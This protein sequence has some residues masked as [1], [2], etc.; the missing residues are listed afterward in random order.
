MNQHVYQIRVKMVDT[1]LHWVILTHAVAHQTSQETF[2]RLV[3][4]KA[5]KG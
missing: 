2:A 5:L 4:I 1:A 3:E